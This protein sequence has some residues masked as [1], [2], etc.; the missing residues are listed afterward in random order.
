MGPKQKI[1][2][3]TFRHTVATL[4]LENGI[5]IRNIQ[6]LLGHSTITTTQIYVKVNARS[7]RRIL[8]KAHPR[9]L[10]EI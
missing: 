4:L 5:D 9:L 1:P 2:P 6:H 10:I 8:E 3:H 7:Q